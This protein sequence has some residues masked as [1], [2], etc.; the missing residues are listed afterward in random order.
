MK[1]NPAKFHSNLFWNDRALGFFEKHRSNNKNSNNNN[2]MSS[3]M[4]SIPDAKIRKVSR[5]DQN[6]TD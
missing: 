4:R 2:K 1:N 6:M 5:T 3:N